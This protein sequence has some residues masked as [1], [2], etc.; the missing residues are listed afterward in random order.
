MAPRDEAKRSAAASALFDNSRTWLSIAVLS[1]VVAGCFSRHSAPVYVA[2]LGI[3]VIA[4]ISILASLRFYSPWWSWAGWLVPLLL[5]AVVLEPMRIGVISP[6]TAM[7]AY[8]LAAVCVF[9]VLF[10]ARVSLKKWVTAG[11]DR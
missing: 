9:G 6:F 3:A 4:L 5:V 11:V 2:A 1:A 8:S 10:V 7:F